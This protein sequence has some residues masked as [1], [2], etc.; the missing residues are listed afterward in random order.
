MHPLDGHLQRSETYC[1]SYAYA[2]P[3][4]LMKIPYI[5]QLADVWS[6]GVIL[7]VMVSCYDLHRHCYHLYLCQGGHVIVVVCLSVCPLATLHKIFLTDLHEIFREGRQWAYEQMTNFAGDPDHDTG[8]TCLGRGMHCPSASRQR[9][10]EP[11]WHNALSVNLILTCL[12]LLLPQP[13]LLTLST[14]HFHHP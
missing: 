7:Y 4:I 11:L 10:I 12:F 6:M 3:E 5:P 13:R 8:K 2:A 14:Y 1:G 9:E